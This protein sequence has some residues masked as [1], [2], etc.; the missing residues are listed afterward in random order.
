MSENR[1]AAAIPQQEALPHKD[2]T[3]A[4]LQRA[5]LQETIPAD[6][7]ETLRS[8]LHKAAAER[9]AAYTRGKSG[10]VTQKQAEAFYASVFCQ[11][12]AVLLGMHSDQA[13]EAALRSQP[14]EVLLEAGQVCTM[15]LYEE[16]KDRF[17]Q[18][19]LLTKQYHT[20]LY[21][22]LLKEFEWFCTKYDARFR[23]AETKVQ[24]SYP[25]LSDDEITENGVIGVHRYYSALLTE[26][27]M[28]KQFPQDEMQ[29]MMC[30]Y[31][32]KYLTEP[33]MIAENI[34]ELALRHALTAALAGEKILTVKLSEQQIRDTEACYAQSSAEML[35]KE[36]ESAAKRILPAEQSACLYIIQSL[37]E[38]AKSMLRR[39]Q[40]GRLSGWLAFVET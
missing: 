23:A 16:A 22:G 10:T 25:L 35:R 29:E 19:Y 28:L 32:E 20:T 36:L 15:K 40:E 11:L 26:A 24:Y 4:L 1:L 34:A 6:T 14:L 39:M 13:A 27:E 18:A 31:A 8:A 38:L 21:R 7:L 12:D 2:Y 9:A 3:M 30:R 33:E 17:R 37:D 5:A